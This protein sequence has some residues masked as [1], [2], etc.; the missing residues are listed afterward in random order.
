[1]S[2]SQNKKMADKPLQRQRFDDVSDAVEF[3]Y[4]TF[5][6]SLRLLWKKKKNSIKS[7]GRS[8]IKSAAG[9]NT[10]KL[11]RNGPVLTQ[12]HRL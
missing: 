7:I 10:C 6:D 12:T 5:A 11:A 1:M 3:Y 8:K 9:K 2:T 4:T